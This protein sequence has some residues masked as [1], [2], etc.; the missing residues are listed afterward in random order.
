[1]TAEQVREKAMMHLLKAGCP[2]S[3]GRLSHCLTVSCAM[4]HQDLAYDPLSRFGFVF[5]PDIRDTMVLL[6][7]CNLPKREAK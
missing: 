7:G 4:L 3:L 1:V 5:L 6:I 2:L